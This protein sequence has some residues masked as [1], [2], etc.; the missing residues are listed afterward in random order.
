M[1][2]V[3]DTTAPPEASAKLQEEPVDI[4]DGPVTPSKRKLAEPDLVTP[5]AK[6]AE[7]DGKHPRREG[8]G[9]K[10][11]RAECCKCCKHPRDPHFRNA[12]CNHCEQ[13][14]RSRNARSRSLWTPQMQEEVAKESLLRR[15]A[16]VVNK[17]SPAER[18]LFKQGQQILQLLGGKHVEE[19]ESKS[20]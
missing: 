3:Q 6:R 12:L 16:A 19:P 13:L 4:A 5:D 2:V 20:G 15:K 8:F 9:G 14:F 11:N 7:P 10:T 17:M 1:T 18:L